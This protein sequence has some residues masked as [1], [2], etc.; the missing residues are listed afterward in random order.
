LIDFDED[1]HGGSPDGQDINNYPEP[2]QARY[3]WMRMVIIG[4]LANQSSF[5]EPLNFKIG[6]IWHSLND[7]FFK[8]FD[9][10]NFEEMAKAIRIG[11]STL[12]EWSEYVQQTAGK[13]TDHYSF[14]G[15]SNSV[16]TEIDVPTEAKPAAEF[17]NNHPLLYINGLLI[18]PRNTSF[19]IDRTKILLSGGVQ[20]NAGDD[21]IVTIQRMDQI[22]PETVIVA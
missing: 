16:N 13:L 21:F 18:D 1:V 8:Y 19:N 5:E 22:V 11:E 17:D 9:G 12:E 14:G 10:T 3:D 2:G 20:L 15:T 6:T 4:L 7:N